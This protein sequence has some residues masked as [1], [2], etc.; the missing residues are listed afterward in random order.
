MTLS[1]RRR[2]QPR[3]SSDPLL[4]RRPAAQSPRFLRSA[5]DEPSAQDFGPW[6]V[7][8][9]PD[10]SGSQTTPLA[11]ISAA[12]A[13]DVQAESS[14]AATDEADHGANDVGNEQ[15]ALPEPGPA[16]APDPALIR[17]LEDAAYKKGL[18]DGQ[19]LEHETTKAQREQERELIRNLGIELRSL[20]QDPERLFQPMKKLALHLAETLVRS[21]LQTSP[22]AINALIEGC[23]SQ[24][25]AHGEP[26]TVSLN[27]A[28]LRLVRSMGESVS[29]QLHLVEDASLR[30]GSVKASFQD[31]A[32]Q[33]LIDHR[34]EALARK[35]LSDPQAWLSRS[36]LLHDVVDAMPDDTPGRN[37]QRS[38]NDITDVS[39][40][41]SEDSS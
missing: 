24:L 31:T 29:A 28:D 10:P 16:A 5:W 14:N 1:D 15:K 11:Q 22:Q 38:D 18:Q 36:T 17:S 7:N 30:V 37:W 23:L 3:W 39:D 20:Q 33:D 4:S 34:L 26:V 40:T 9:R 6:R 13:T 12:Q 32:V 21:E 41:D 2:E 25:D 35:V 8:L 27:P 19:N